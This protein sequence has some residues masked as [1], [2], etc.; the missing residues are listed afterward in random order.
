MGYVRVAGVATVEA[1]DALL[2][3]LRERGLPSLSRALCVALEE[4]R[5]GGVVN[6]ASTS[7]G[8]STSR[9]VSGVI[10]PPSSTEGVD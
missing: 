3:L 5:L 10:N 2:K 9:G 6:P 4:W 1:R 7:E 8:Q